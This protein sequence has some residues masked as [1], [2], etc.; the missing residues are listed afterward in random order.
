MVVFGNKTNYWLIGIAVALITIH[1]SLSHELGSDFLN[2]GFLFWV[3]TIVLIWQKRDK[4][5]WQSNIISAAVGFTILAFVLYRSLNLFPQDYFLQISPLLSLLGWGLLAS[6][7]RGLKQ[8]DRAFLVLAFLAIPWELAYMFDVAQITAQFSGFILWL[9]GFTVSRQGVWLIL[10]TGSVEVYNGCSGVRAIAQL[11]GICWI[12][13]NIVPTNRRQ[14]ILLPAIAIAIGFV[15]NGVR[16]ALMAILVALSDSQSFDYWHVGTGSLIFSAIA[17]LVF[18][19][20]SAKTINME[21][22]KL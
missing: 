6:G 9:S 10:P 7:F 18:I 12:I 2:F 11:L 3:I 1:I 14:K 20:V 22:A 4:L 5:F 15:I 17:V 16:V 19:A 21:L 8:Y 13:L